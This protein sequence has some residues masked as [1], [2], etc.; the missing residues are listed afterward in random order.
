MNMNMI[1]LV[2]AILRSA[3]VIGKRVT[4][5]LPSLIGTWLRI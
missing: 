2:V 3:V 1:S 5:N 4:P